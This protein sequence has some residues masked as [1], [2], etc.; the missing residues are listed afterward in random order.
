MSS[1]SA[2]FFSV[3]IPTYNR[4]ERLFESVQSIFNQSYK[5]FELVI[6]DDGSTDNTVEVVKSFQDDRIRYFK[7]QNEERAIARNFGISQTTGD[8]VTFLDSDDQLYPHALKEALKI[9]EQKNRLEWFHLA[10]EIK[11]EKGK[12]LRKENKRKS[13]INLSL[14]T[15]N[16]LSCIGVF[17]RK[18]IMQKHQFNEDPDIIGSEDYLLWLELASNYPLK[19]SNNISAVMMQHGGRS[20]VNFDKQQLVR[21]IEK[22]I[23]YAIENKTIQ[24]LLRGNMNKFKS[25]RYLYLANHLSR[26]SARLPSV[27]FFFLSLINFPSIIFHRNAFSYMKSF[28]LLKK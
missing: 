8:Y 23:Q 6:I 15:G 24:N 26:S 16:H 14:I 19:Y 4:A 17:V 9:I 13:N 3:I 21:R 7:K 5:N 10:Y 25:H 1:E 11:D 12:V 27:K 18:D 2:V 20:V 22:S 28:L